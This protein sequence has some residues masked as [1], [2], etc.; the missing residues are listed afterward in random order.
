M[1]TTKPQVL[2]LLGATHES[3][4]A[5][6]GEQLAARLQTRSLLRQCPQ[7]GMAAPQTGKVLHSSCETHPAAQKKQ[8]DSP[9]GP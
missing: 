5:L 1:A 6:F 9:A 7:D 8:I 2:Q 3:A 4:P